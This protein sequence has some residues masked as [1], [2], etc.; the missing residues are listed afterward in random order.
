MHQWLLWTERCSPKQLTDVFC[1]RFTNELRMIRSDLLLVS[2]G[3]LSVQR[4]SCLIK[5]MLMKFARQH[6]YSPQFLWTPCLNDSYRADMYCVKIFIGISV[7]RAKTLK[8]CRSEYTLLRYL[9]VLRRTVL[10][11]ISRLMKDDYFWW[12]RWSSCT[13]L[14]RME[15]EEAPHKLCPVLTRPSQDLLDSQR[16]TSPTCVVAL[17]GK[18]SK[19]DLC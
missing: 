15:V 17:L 5:L 16:C 18:R 6:A 4:F 11:V 13:L 3:I 12:L 7:K 1:A 9:V 10:Y 19:R 8:C 14:Y 2:K